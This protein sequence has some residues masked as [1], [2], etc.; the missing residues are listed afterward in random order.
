[1]TRV[2]VSKMLAIV[3]RIVNMTVDTE[4]NR[5]KLS[6]I[7]SSSSSKA[8]GVASSANE[9]RRLENDIAALSDLLNRLGAE[10]DANAS[11][12]G[13]EADV[14][15]DDLTEI[16]E[17]ALQELLET[18]E[19]AN[20]LADGVEGRVDVLIESLESLLLG[21]DRDAVD[22]PEDTTGSSER[23]GTSNGKPVEEADMLQEHEAEE[24][25]VTRWG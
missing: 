24:P 16:D 8:N 10:A 13:D 7:M 9:S 12:P 20:D 23:S 19:R 2:R 14:G 1:M 21:L 3:S 17:R 6:F 11:T 22:D 5:L 4:T 15:R 18:M 25:Q